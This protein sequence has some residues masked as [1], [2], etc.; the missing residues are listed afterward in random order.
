MNTN[1]RTLSKIASF[2]ALPMSGKLDASGLASAVAASF[3][4]G[5]TA[6]R[7]LRWVLDH[8]KPGMQALCD[9]FNTLRNDGAKKQAHS[10][11]SA[12]NRE[13][14]KR[15][16]G[17]AL[18]VEGEKA[19]KPTHHIVSRQ[20]VYSVAS[21]APVK[22]AAPVRL[23][24]ANA[25]LLLVAQMRESFKLAADASPDVIRDAI[26]SAASR[27]AAIDSMPTRTRKTA[28]APLRRAA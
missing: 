20:H 25:A 16:E 10:E 13:L 18:N 5:T 3:A 6:A 1:T 12:V 11:Y 19:A 23:I 27:L 28:A 2:E 17:K 22:K 9:R 8:G 26:Q 21:G 15:A 14:H 7:M 4:F 24:D